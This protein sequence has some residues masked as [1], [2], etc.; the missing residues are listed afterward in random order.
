[1]RSVICIIS[2]LGLLLVSACEKSGTRKLY[3][4]DGYFR[5]YFEFKDGST[6]NYYLNNDTNV[7][8]TVV[9]SNYVAGV[10]LWE[11]MEQE[12]FTYTLNSSIDSQMIVRTA[13]TPDNT[14]RW[15]LLYNQNNFRQIAELYY[16][17]NQIG[18]VQGNND[19]VSYL[20]S[21]N[22]GDVVFN[23]VIRLQSNRKRVLKELYFAK[24][25]GVIRRDYVD[26]RI[27]L[28]KSYSLK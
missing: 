12:F 18:G 3:V 4:L 11:D 14:G 20:S 16:N 27:F 23:D 6:W 21:F 13:A 5:S 19:T 17:T 15:A 8:E 26:G 28:L 10:M 24:N 25:V 1:V 7:R 2:A 9:L 22:V